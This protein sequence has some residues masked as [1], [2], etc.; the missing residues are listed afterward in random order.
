MNSPIAIEYIPTRM[1][2]INAINFAAVK[3]SC[4]FIDNFVEMQFM[5]VNS[6]EII[7]VNLQSVV[8]YGI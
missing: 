3:M 2:L 4:T 6:T 7:N 8:G 5:V 1:M